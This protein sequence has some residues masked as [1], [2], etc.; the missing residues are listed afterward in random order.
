[1]S[2]TTIR[3]N[4]LDITR[5]GEQP[6]NSPETQVVVDD[7]FLVAQS[8]TAG[9]SNVIEKNGEKS[10]TLPD[11][12]KY[13]HS[14]KVRETFEHPDFPDQLMIIATDRISTHDIVHK[15]TIPWKWEVLTQISNFWFEKFKTNPSTSHI[16][17][18]VVENPVWPDDFPEELKSRTVIVK[19]LKALPIEAILRWY[20]YWSALKWYNTETWLLKTWEDVWKNL[21]KSSKLKE[22]LFT[23]ST[24][25]NSWDVNIDF[26]WMVLK[27]EEWLPK[28]GFGNIDASALANKIREYTILNPNIPCNLLNWL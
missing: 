14:W 13:I 25:S 3:V 15:G 1:M 16:K 2:N 28:N 17:T 12:Y 11:R 26:D 27:L 10:V 23:P 22:P 21:K 18:H 4:D 5:Q 8:L 24:K 19:K 6:W 9:K 7:W 20:L